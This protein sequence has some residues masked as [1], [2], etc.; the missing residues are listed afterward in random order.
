LRTGRILPDV[1]G[2]QSA[3]ERIQ[4][5]ADE[6]ALEGRAKQSEANEDARQRQRRA[7]TLQDAKYIRLSGVARIAGVSSVPSAEVSEQPRAYVLPVESNG[8]P[9]TKMLVGNRIEGLEHQ[10]KRAKDKRVHS[11]AH[12]RAKRYGLPVPLKRGERWKRRLP[13][14]CW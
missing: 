9:R 8:N 14:I 10:H 3:A 7:E 13:Q 11:G 2:G 5:D 1:L 4:Q 12:R 6:R